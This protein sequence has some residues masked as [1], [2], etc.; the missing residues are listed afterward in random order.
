MC[1]EVFP[2]SSA[3]PAMPRTNLSL[4]GKVDRLV[5][6]FRLVGLA[7]DVRDRSADVIVT[8]KAETVL[9]L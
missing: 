8:A 5:S 3:N 6:S 2:A 4:T 7:I 9:K 1:Y